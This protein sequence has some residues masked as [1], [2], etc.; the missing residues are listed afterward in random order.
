VS[1]PPNYGIV[2]RAM[3]RAP[4][5]NDNW[6]AAHSRSCGGTFH[7]FKEPLPKPKTARAAAKYKAGQSNGDI[8]KLLS[9]ASSSISGAEQS[10]LAKPAGS[11]VEQS[12]VFP[13]FVSPLTMAAAA[14]GAAGA[15]SSKAK[16]VL[17]EGTNADE[18]SLQ[19]AL[20]SSMKEVPPAKKKQCLLLGSGAASC[21]GSPAA[22]ATS[23]TSAAAANQARA[24]AG[25]LQQ[26]SPQQHEA[27][28]IV[29]LDSDE[30]E[31]ALCLAETRESA[32]N[33]AAAVLA[34]AAAG[35][36]PRQLQKQHLDYLAVTSQPVSGT[37]FDCTDYKNATPFQMCRCEDKIIG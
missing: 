4:G 7:K 24:A 13:E 11:T 25:Y 20:F 29:V 33:C 10:L 21:L 19:L 6:W 28:I 2:K 30:D 1:K 9:A 34:N 27:E 8:R 17:D 36:G 22:G 26:L 32:E 3:N 35:S 31:S 18:A 12:H 14:E 23:R 5:P 15:Q 37:Y 16:F